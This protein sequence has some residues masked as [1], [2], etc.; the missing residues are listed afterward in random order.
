[1]S[2]A[3][4]V[5]G[6]SAAA[7]DAGAGAAGGNGVP[8]APAPGAVKVP[9]KKAKLSDEKP[10]D[11][12]ELGLDDEDVQM[13]KQAVPVTVRSLF[14]LDLTFCQQK[15]ETKAKAAQF[16][17][18]KVPALRLA[19]DHWASLCLLSKCTTSMK[20][21]RVRRDRRR[22]KAKMNLEKAHDAQRKAIDSE[23]ANETASDDTAQ[24]VTYF[25]LGHVAVG[26]VEVAG[27]GEV[28]RRG[29]AKVGA[30]V[31]VVGVG[32]VAGGAGWVGGCGH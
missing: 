14:N 17:E 28:G 19:E 25:Q 7:T 4:A 6:A 24:L 5:T 11:T 20:A 9:R 8:I 15:A 1:M 21:T 30:V 3:A 22:L 12:P 13:L 26:H 16:L 29:G 23:V 32:G 2:G 18:R 31:G 10:Y 27:A